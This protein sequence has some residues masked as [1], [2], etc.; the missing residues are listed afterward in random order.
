MHHSASSHN[1][2][3]KTLV[4]LNDCFQSLGTM[5]IVTVT[6][7]VVVVVVGFPDVAILFY[8]QWA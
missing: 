3:E 8:I 1:A 2:F 4:K 6:V 5:D 7:V